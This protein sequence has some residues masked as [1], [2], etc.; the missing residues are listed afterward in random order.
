MRGMVAAIQF[1]VFCLL[2]CYKNGSSI[3][4]AHIFL[5]DSTFHLDDVRWKRSRMSLGRP[6]MFLN[7]SNIDLCPDGK[8]GFDQMDILCSGP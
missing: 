1:R 6:S 2:F 7:T 5:Y 3:D 8:A 4:L